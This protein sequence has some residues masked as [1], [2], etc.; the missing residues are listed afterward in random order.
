[1]KTICGTCEKRKKNFQCRATCS[2]CGAETRVCETCYYE[3]GVA[4]CDACR[5]KFDKK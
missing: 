2:L 3:S 5:D 1:M 4:Y